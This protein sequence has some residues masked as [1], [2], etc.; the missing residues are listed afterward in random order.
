MLSIQQLSTKHLPNQIG[1]F[2]PQ[3]AT[4]L[5]NL[6][7]V[8]KSRILDQQATFVC[9]CGNLRLTNRKIVVSVDLDYEGTFRGDEVPGTRRHM[10]RDVYLASNCEQFRDA[11]DGTSMIAFSGGI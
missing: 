1:I 5:T 10:M 6:F 4:Y 8:F 2:D 7:V 11:R 9:I 3:L